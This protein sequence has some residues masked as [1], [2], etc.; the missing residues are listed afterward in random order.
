M[1][2]SSSKFLALALLS[3]SLVAAPV[4]SYAASDDQNP[5]PPATDTYNKG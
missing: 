5:K 4:I 2:K 3:A 1:S